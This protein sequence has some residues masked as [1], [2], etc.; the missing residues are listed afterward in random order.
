M[1]T[2]IAV[3][4]YYLL[5]PIVS[6]FNKKMSRTWATAIVFILVIALLGVTI[7]FLFH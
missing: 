1:P 7:A 6:L 3:L 5:D 4:F 2:I